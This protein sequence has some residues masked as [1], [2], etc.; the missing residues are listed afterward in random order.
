MQF[1]IGHF[2]YAVQLAN[3]AKLLAE[4]NGRTKVTEQ[5]LNDCRQLFLDAKSSAK[6]LSLNGIGDNPTVH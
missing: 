1:L 5:D 4:V 3:P 2:R 6:F